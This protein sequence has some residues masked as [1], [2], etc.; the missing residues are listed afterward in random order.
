M[1]RRPLPPPVLS[2]AEGLKKHHYRK[3][4]SRGFAE[5]PPGS[6]G[7]HGHNV[8]SQ[9]KLD[10]DY[11][12]KHPEAVKKEYC[13]YQYDRPSD[14]ALSSEQLNK[15]V[16]ETPHRV[17]KLGFL[18]LSS[19]LPHRPSNQSEGPH[20]V[21]GTPS[22]QIGWQAIEETASRINSPRPDS[23]AGSGAA[24]P[25][26]RFSQ[27]DISDSRSEKNG[28]GDTIHVDDPA[29]RRS[30]MFTDGEQ[31]TFEDDQDITYQAPILASDELAKDPS[32]YENPPAVEPPPERRG[33]SF[34]MEEPVSRPTSRPASI[35]KEAS[36]EARSTPLE[37]VQEYEPLFPEDEKSDQARPKQTSAA[38]GV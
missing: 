3:T 29:R 11:Y 31:P 7:L 19:F 28:N 34:E 1:C 21:A 2:L 14:T 30:V 37:D 22:E 24:T 15:I 25:Q 12:S 32:A 5:L 6:Y 16:R 9:V 17:G 10:A 18:V 13:H 36:F 33:S 38:E 20:D 26:K 23:K 4:S 27:P 8:V 35:Y